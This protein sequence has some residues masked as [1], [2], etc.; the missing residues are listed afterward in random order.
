MRVQSSCVG[1]GQGSPSLSAYPGLDEAIMAEAV[2]PSWNDGPASAAI[3]DFVERVTRQGSPDF[4]PPPERIA[5]FDN[6]GT[7]WCEQPLQP[8]LFFLIDRVKQLAEK[9]PSLRDRQPFKGLLERD[10]KALHAA[11]QKGLMEL[12]F[13]TH[14]GMTEEAFEDI[15]QK[16]LDSARHP[17]YG[18]PFTKC[19]FLPQIEL[20]A[21]LRANGFKTFIVSGGGIDLIRAFAEAVYGIAREQVIGSSARL[22]FEMQG[23]KAVLMKL[24]ELN[25]FD[26]RDVKPANIGLHI[27]RRPILAFG[28]SDGDLAMLRYCSSGPGAR[29]AL[30]IH[31]DDAVREVAYDRDFKLSPLAEALDRAA[32][33][34]ITLVSMKNDWKAIFPG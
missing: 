24:A 34:G 9:D 3:V 17:K 21:Y 23:D 16:W 31:H 11:G 13:A 1:A 15:A 18:R 2:L 8:Q 28:N 30:L 4:V 33:Y 29:L 27:G 7:L 14:S 32:D 22:R 26:D 12:A 25:S 5:T 10:M 19:V 6:D 20:L